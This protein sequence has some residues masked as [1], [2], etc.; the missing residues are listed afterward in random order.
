[1]EI[2]FKKIEVKEE[3]RCG[4]GEEERGGGGPPI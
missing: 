4:I 2:V 3:Y 1:M